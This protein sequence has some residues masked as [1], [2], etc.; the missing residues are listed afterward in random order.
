MRTRKTIISLLIIV[1]A[2]LT[3]FLTSQ[4]KKGGKE[5]S[6]NDE[7]KEVSENTEDEKN[8]VR[9]YTD[10][11]VYKDEKFKIKGFG[12]VTSG[13]KKVISSEVSGKIRQHVTLKAG[14][15]FKKGNILF[16]VIDSEFVM[17]LIARRSTFLNILSQT[18]ADL[19]IDYEEYYSTWETFFDS[20][21][22]EKSLPELP[23]VEDKRLKI[24][25]NTKGVIEQYYT[26]RGLEERKK[27]YIVYAPYS[28]SIVS[29]SRVN[30]EIVS[31]GVSV[32]EIVNTEEWEIEIPV[33]IKDER[34]L[35]INEKADIL[36]ANKNLI[37]EGKISRK[38]DYIDRTTE[39][40]SIFLKIT[41][42]TQKLFSG[43]YLTVV[44][45]HNSLKDVFKVSRSGLYN[46]N[47][48]YELPNNNNNNN[49]N[50]SI[51]KITVTVVRLGDNY[52]YIKGIPEKTIL[53]TQALIDVTE[54]TPVKSLEKSSK[55]DSLPQ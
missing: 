36:D 12:M 7:N 39:S 24:Y 14:V 9:V 25:L 8:Y 51:K 40:V 45:P 43:Q 26:I 18:L 31:S 1:L 35:S 37:A 48:M 21:S 34:F 20:I 23:T 33:S 30:G 27:K 55:Q 16:E 54:N 46:Q 42:K 3:V 49:N 44:F 2:V 15:S 6:T 5:H 17:S 52:A 29:V 11:V 50:N 22:P 13:E 38:G 28:G 19:K 10:E 4:S 47:E 32:L 41:K 53:I